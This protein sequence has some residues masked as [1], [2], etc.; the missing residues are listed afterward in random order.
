[1]SNTSNPTRILVSTKRG[2]FAVPEEREGKRKGKEG[3]RG[4][5]WIEDK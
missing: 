1:M 2:F 4:G 3:R 5:G